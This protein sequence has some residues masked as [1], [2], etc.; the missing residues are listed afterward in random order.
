MA[1]DNLAM[2]KVLDLH[3][4]ICAKTLC[5]KKATVVL[6]IAQ[7]DTLKALLETGINDTKK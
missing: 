7:D 3:E 5:V 6:E 2:Y 1:E 4:I